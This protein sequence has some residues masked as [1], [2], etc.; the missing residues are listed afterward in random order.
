MHP[1]PLSRPLI[2]TATPWNGPISVGR[3][4]L[5]PLPGQ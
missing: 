4:S 2:E 3:S 1:L 5:P